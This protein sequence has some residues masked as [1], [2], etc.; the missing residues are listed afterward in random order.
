MKRLALGAA[1]LLLTTGGTCSRSQD[2]DALIAE[3]QKQAAPVI[4]AL[5]R[6]RDDKGVYPDNW[7]DLVPNYV[8][9]LPRDTDKIDFSYSHNAGK[10]IYVLTFSFDAAPLGISQCR[11]YSD[12]AAWSCAAKI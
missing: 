8:D 1:A 12:T 9:A 2:R 3:G 6:Y 10:A 7:A 11:Y 5:G 4:D